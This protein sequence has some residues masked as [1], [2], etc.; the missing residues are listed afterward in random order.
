MEKHPEIDQLLAV[1]TVKRSEVSGLRAESN[2]SHLAAPIN[3]RLGSCLVHTECG[4]R[5][6][7]NTNHRVVTSSDV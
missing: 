2:Q 7:T 3:C 5:V 6:D 4:L 1:F